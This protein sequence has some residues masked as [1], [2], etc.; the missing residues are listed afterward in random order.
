MWVGLFSIVLCKE[1]AER[2]KKKKGNARFRREPFSQ[3]GAFAQTSGLDSNGGRRRCV[4]PPLPHPVAGVL[5]R[6]PSSRRSGCQ[7]HASVQ[8]LTTSQLLEQFKGVAV[9]TVQCS[10][11]PDRADVF[12]ASD[13]FCWSFII[14]SVDK[15]KRVD[16]WF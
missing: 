2:K 7:T 12:Q 13:S 10:V 9:K 15:E 11:C 4:T 5:I 14:Y 1:T 8:S 16:V 6:V 3:L